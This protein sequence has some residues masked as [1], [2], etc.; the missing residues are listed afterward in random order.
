MLE[1]SGKE[2]PDQIMAD[3]YIHFRKS[4]IGVALEDSIDE[5]VKTQSI[6]PHLAQK[7][8][9]QFDRS[10]TEA[11]GKTRAKFTVKVF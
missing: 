5:L 9:L 4:T 3:A 11:L 10:M 6:T 7:L 1:H 8:M 2:E